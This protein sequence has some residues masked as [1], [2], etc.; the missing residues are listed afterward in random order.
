MS[1]SLVL[2]LLLFP[3]IALAQGPR[4]SPAFHS[5]P[6]TAWDDASTGPRIAPGTVAMPA[7]GSRRAR[8]ALIGGGIGAAAGLVVC[9]IISNIADDAAVD[10]FTTCTAKGY[11]LTGSIGF[12][13]G[14]L[15]GWLASS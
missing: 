9:T 15:V 5:G 3:S 4:V 7:A 11:L 14:F 2:S 6:A 12:G 1:K 8:N 13:T 10:R